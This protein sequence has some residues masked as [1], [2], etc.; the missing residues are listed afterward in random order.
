MH[1]GGAVGVGEVAVTKHSG[2]ATVTAHVVCVSPSEI[3][4]WP[5]R[6]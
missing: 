4:R 3:A 5:W 2:H 1:H 6:A